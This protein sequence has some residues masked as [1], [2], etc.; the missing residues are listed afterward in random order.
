[1]QLDYE[2]IQFEY[3]TE[4]IMNGKNEKFIFTT[5]NSNHCIMPEA[6]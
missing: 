3:L 1:M 2:I 6:K 4:S 5:V